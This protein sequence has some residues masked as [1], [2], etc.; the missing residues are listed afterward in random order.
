M[1]AAETFEELEPGFRRKVMEFG[2]GRIPFWGF[3]GMRV[4]DVR[5][6]WARLTLSFRPEMANANGVAH[7][8]VAFALADSAIGTALVGLLAPGERISTVE[9]KINYTRPFS[10]GELAAE[11]RIAHKGSQTAVGE[12][13]VRDS[14]GHLVAK[15][16]ATYA[17][18]EG[19]PQDP[20]WT[21]Q[22]GA[23]HDR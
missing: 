12:A 1:Q 4:E 20:G 23:H 9:M 19:R 16:L 22:T 3:F 13:E 7:G 15:A 2:P 21:Q 5:K 6:G 17:V 14:R 8:A 10:G 11:A 18:S